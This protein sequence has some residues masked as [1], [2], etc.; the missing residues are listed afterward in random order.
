MPK[1]SE[2]NLYDYLKT[3]S[4]SDTTI[5]Q[6]DSATKSTFINE[7]NIGFWKGPLTVARVIESS[8]TYAH[9][10]PLP[11]AG[12]IIANSIDNGASATVKPTGTELWKVEAISNMADMTVSLFDGSTYCPIQTGTTPGVYSNL[13]ITPTLYLIIA[14]ASGDTAISNVAYSKVGL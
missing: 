13:I 2:P 1:K 6:L 4:V 10:L 7:R 8:R 12:A 3:N 11:E 9:G 14:N 5:T